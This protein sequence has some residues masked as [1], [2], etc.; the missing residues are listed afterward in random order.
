MA[1]RG[2]V[3]NVNTVYDDLTNINRKLVSKYKLS[4]IFTSAVLEKGKQKVVRFNYKL[5][6]EDDLDNVVEY[7]S[8]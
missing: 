2:R 5:E 3:V 8:K 6:D 1:K 4:K 7:M